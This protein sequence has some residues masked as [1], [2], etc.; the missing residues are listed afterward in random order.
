[1]SDLEFQ[2]SAPLG[3]EGLIAN[4]LE[5]VPAA[6]KETTELAARTTMQGWLFDRCRDVYDKEVKLHESLLEEQI[7]ERMAAGNPYVMKQ[8][9][10]GE[11]FGI[12]KPENN[13]NTKEDYVVSRCNA[14]AL[15][16][17]GSLTSQYGSEPLRVK[18]TMLAAM[19]SHEG[20]DWHGDAYLLNDNVRKSKLRANGDG[21][22]DAKL[23]IL[24]H[25]RQFLVSVDIHS[26]GGKVIETY[27]YRG[28]WRENGQPEYP[29]GLK[30]VDDFLGLYGSG[31]HEDVPDLVSVVPL[32]DK[33]CQGRAAEIITCRELLTAV[34]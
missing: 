8:A 3:L 2:N 6:D 28:N 12:N 33:Y 15:D 26:L 30:G 32:L 19:I 22:K 23:N 1:M 24:Y 16:F 11:L 5:K 4:A 34:A 31:T 25:S 20:T 14:L 18:G 9:G 21:L 10:L 13:P 17:E 29:Q 27:E 7:A